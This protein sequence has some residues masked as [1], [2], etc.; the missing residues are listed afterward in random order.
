MHPYQ[1]YPPHLHCANAPVPVV[2]APFALCK[3][4][5]T[6][7]T[8]PIY[9]VQMHPYQSYPPHLHSANAPVPVVP[10]PFALCKCTRTSCTHPS[11]QKKC[12]CLHFFQI[13]NERGYCLRLLRNV[14]NI[15]RCFSASVF[16]AAWAAVFSV[17]WSS[18]LRFFFCRSA[19][20]STRLVY[21]LSAFLITSS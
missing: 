10:A 6:S 4:T 3:C 9:T 15:W 11:A 21:F 12:S 2:P 5:R 19:A 17:I 20:S 14:S 13:Y 7:C 16:W 18:S 1:S 8:Y